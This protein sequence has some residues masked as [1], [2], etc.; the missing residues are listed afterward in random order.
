MTWVF[1][2]AIFALNGDPAPGIVTTQD[3]FAISWTS[4]ESASK[5][6]RLLQTKSEA[7]ARSLFRLCSQSQWNYERA[8]K[9]LQAGSWRQALQKVLYRPYDVRW[10]V[11]DSNVAVHRRDRVMRHLLAGDNLAVLLTRQTREQWDVLATRHIAA[12]K[13]CAAYDI[14]SLFPLYLYP[15]PDKPLGQGLPP[16][17]HAGKGGR[18]PNLSPEFVAEVQKKTG[19]QFV[20]DGKGDLKKS[21]GPEDLFDYIYAVFHSPTYRKRYAEFLKS[22]FPRVPMTSNAKVFRRLCALG[23]ELVGLHL[24]ESDAPSKSMT[25]YP[26]KGDNVVAKGCPSSPLKNSQSRS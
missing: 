15:S 24:M 21:F 26:I 1:R 18:V 6:E 4:E 11:Y 17:W 9:D 12:H 16:D 5:V 14:N 20:S 23:A 19:L 7:E 10:T 3:D 2:E 25:N 8:M 22:D 13:A